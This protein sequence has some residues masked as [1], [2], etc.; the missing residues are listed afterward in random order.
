MVSHWQDLVFTFGTV[1]FTIALIPALKRKQYPPKSTCFITAPMLI[2]YV[3][4]EITLNLWFSALT[5]LISAMMWLTLG[6]IQLNDRD[7]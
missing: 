7:N 1:V 3:V 6:I 5:T 2:L 4:A